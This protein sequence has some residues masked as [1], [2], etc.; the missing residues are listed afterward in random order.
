M[1]LL[2]RDH[3]S[4]PATES[5]NVEKVIVLVV[6]LKS[7]MPERVD[8]STRPRPVDYLCMDLVSG[9]EIRRGWPNP[10]K[11]FSMHAVILHDCLSST[12]VPAMWVSTLRC[13]ISRE[14]IALTSH[15]SRPTVEPSG[16]G[17]DRWAISGTIITRPWF[18]HGKQD[19]AS[20]RRI[21]YVCRAMWK[22]PTYG[23]KLNN[24][25]VRA[26]W[27]NVT[28]PACLPFECSHD[29]VLL[30]ARKRRRPG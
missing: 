7:S 19:E 24:V 18:S 23:N 13:P 27:P 3:L 2:A 28:P 17:K 30:V 4:S 12:G 5:D 29:G 1:A 20:H 8:L 11:G 6:R 22:N 21:M 16:E 15:F 10:F 9:D 25:R 14:E 26:S